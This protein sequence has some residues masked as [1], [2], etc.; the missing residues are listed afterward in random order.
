MINVAVR[1]PTLLFGAAINFSRSRTEPLFVFT[2]NAEHEY[3]RRAFF[4]ECP[5]YR[6][7]L[8]AVEHTALTDYLQL[9]RELMQGEGCSRRFARCTSTARRT[10]T[11]KNMETIAVD[12][13]G[14]PGPYSATKL[15][16]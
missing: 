6:E 3:C 12:V 8:R 11:K 10:Y 5:E 14:M 1:F 4:P 7:Q 16:Q 2:V 9:S 13:L 15:Q